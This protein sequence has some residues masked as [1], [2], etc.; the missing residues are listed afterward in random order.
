M[1]SEDLVILDESRCQNTTNTSR[2]LCE[3]TIDGE[4]DPNILEKSGKRY[5]V[6]AVGFQGVNCPSFIFFNQHN[7]S[8][9]FIKALCNYQMRRIENIEVINILYEILSDPKINITNIKLELLKEKSEE[10]FEKVFDEDNH[11]LPKKLNYYC[12]KNKITKYKINKTQQDNLRIALYNKRLI[13]LL[14]SERRL[15]IILDNARIHTSNFTEEMC[16]LLSI[17]LVFLPK[18]SPFLNPI[19]D[20]WKDIKREIYNEDFDTLDDLIDLFE[21]YFYEKVD[22]FSYIENWLIEYFARNFR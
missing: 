7:N 19:E 8:N 9:N 18:Y 3:P 11:L 2:R 16:E 10:D 1:E 21:N 4:K 22:N 13:E 20:L 14:K 5:G 15:N 17:D 6:N 12:M